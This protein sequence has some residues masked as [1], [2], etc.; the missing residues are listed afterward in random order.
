MTY[1][2]CTR[3]Q[4][5]LNQVFIKTTVIS[6]NSAFSFVSRERQRVAL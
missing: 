6:D 3:I 2:E 5:L 4:G 1:N